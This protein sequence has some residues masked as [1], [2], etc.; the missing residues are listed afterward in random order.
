MQTMNANSNQSMGCETEYGTLVNVLV[1]KPEHMKITEIINETQ[2]HY[3]S[4]NIDVDRALKQHEEFVSLLQN[5]NVDVGYIPAHPRFNEQVFTRDIGF[6]IGQH[7]YISSLA[8]D[9]RKEEVEP[10]IEFIE[11][12]NITY[13][14]LTGPSIEGGDVIINGQTI[15]VGI[16]ERTTLSAA[17]QL[18]KTLPAYTV[19]PL[20][21]REDILHLDC[22]FNIVDEK[23]A[24]LFP[25]AFKQKDVDLLKQTFH[26]IEVGGQEQFQLGTNVLSIGGR[27]V[28]SLPQNERVNQ[29]LRGAGFEVLEVDLSEII[30]SGG[31]F[32]C[33]TLPIN[34]QS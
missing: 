5:H 7:L 10:L 1:S 29:E 9:L 23:T 6:C 16:S 26:C 30:K 13:T 34:R 2:K 25:D 32:R 18:Q 11:E 3:A 21:L 12:M 22:A 27:K 8:S 28:I 20:E 17:E 33:C 4:E 15:Y 31:S 24:L 14:Q 19:I